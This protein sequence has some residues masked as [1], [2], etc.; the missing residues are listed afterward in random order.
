L[1]VFFYAKNYNKGVNKVNIK[2]NISF[3]KKEIQQKINTGMTIEE[4]VEQANIIIT[5]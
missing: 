3:D 5:F 2:M 1:E 4:I